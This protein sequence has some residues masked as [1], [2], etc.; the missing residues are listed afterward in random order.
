MPAS[1]SSR[2]PPVAADFRSCNIMQ[3]DS[4]KPKK[5]GRKHVTTACVPC[6][7]SKIRVCLIPILFFPFLSFALIFLFWFV[8]IFVAFTD[9]IYHRIVRRSFP[10]LPQLPKKRERMQISAWRRQAKV[11]WRK[12]LVFWRI[13][14][15]DTDH[16][17]MT[18]ECLSGL[19]PSFFLPGLTSYLNSFTTMD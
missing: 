6:R 19:L 2:S 5:A 10:A 16:I 3:P 12:H 14:A 8:L 15:I 9:S 18:S 4:E 1:Q 17:H 11:G 13:Q 7:E